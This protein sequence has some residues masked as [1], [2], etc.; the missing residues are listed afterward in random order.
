MPVSVGTY[1]V[2]NLNSVFLKLCSV[3]RRNTVYFAEHSTVFNTEKIISKG[4]SG[5]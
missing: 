2:G 4:T 5:H 1:L 3:S